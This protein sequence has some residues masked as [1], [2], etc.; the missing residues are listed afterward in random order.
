[1]LCT[2]RT[3]ALGVL[4]SFPIILSSQSAVRPTCPPNPGNASPCLRINAEASPCATGTTF[5][6]VT[7]TNRDVSARVLDTPAS[8][9]DVRDAR[10]QA[11]WIFGDGHFSFP[12]PNGSKMEDD[13]TLIQNHRYHRA[14]EYMLKTGMVEKKS[15]TTTSPNE[16]RKIIING[17]GDGGTPNDGASGG[18]PTE[19]IRSNKQVVAPPPPTD[20]TAQV[21][22]IRGSRADIKASGD[23]HLGGHEIGF[24]VSAYNQPNTTMLFF[25]NAVMLDTNIGY[26]PVAD[27]YKPDVANN[28][29]PDYAAKNSF[30]KSTMSALPFPTVRSPFASFMAQNVETQPKGIPNGFGEF[31]F[32]PVM[33]T[34]GIPSGN[35][36]LD[37]KMMGRSKYLVLVLSGVRVD[38]NEL[39]P[40]G[41]SN[42]IINLST[43][44]R[45][46][47]KDIL[48]LHGL[49]IQYDSVTLELRNAS[50]LGT[51]INIVG[52]AVLE[53]EIKAVID[54]T[55]LKVE[56]ICPDGNGQYQVDLHLTIC[57]EGN[58]TENSIDVSIAR[59]MTVV[60]AP[61][62]DLARGNSADFG[63]SAAD[64]WKLSYDRGLRGAYENA[65]KVYIPSCVDIYF[66]VKTDWAGAQKFS[67]EGAMTATVTF[68]TA[69]YNATQDF[70]S[71][72]TTTPVVENC[73]YNCGEC[74]KQDDW[75]GCI[76]WLAVLFALA[77]VFWFWWKNQ[78][79]D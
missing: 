24:A 77:L 3:A 16:R 18:R 56:K 35:A 76:W 37:E 46:S 72:P 39:V 58:A 52:A 70:K 38:D 75:S 51:G 71:H 63:W 12:N 57:N 73:G 1:M 33:G 69:I 61:E 14:G 64:P 9:C 53:H 17:T 54:P 23:A 27:L 19:D 40:T 25:Y 21:A 29:A 43:G 6:D 49:F 42:T 5:G 74:N 48:E 36:L 55:E 4:L 15:N 32:F 65:D 2:L 62:I 67:N 20:G 78:Q 31:R 44:A 26:R 28:Y 60:S 30:M 11:F 7:T 13:A 79:E 34:T 41:P 8:L 22:H 68:N 10:Y 50:G 45:D 59:A 47:I 66:K